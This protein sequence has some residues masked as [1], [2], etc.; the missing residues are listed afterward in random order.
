MDQLPEDRNC[1]KLYFVLDRKTRQWFKC[2]KQGLITGPLKCLEVN[3]TGYYMAR[4]A[5]GNELPF[6]KNEV[7]M[8]FRT[9]PSD[10][11]SGGAFTHEG[12]EQCVVLGE[13][14]MNSYWPKMIN[15]SLRPPAYVYMLGS[16]SPLF[17]AM[18][19]SFP[20][21]GRKSLQASTGQA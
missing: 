12:Q 4:D 6:N 2:C 19:P 14:C 9:R 17:S 20:V 16:P 5:E 13:P 3:P 10:S 1:S 15:S 21:S 8:C 7:Q 18:V 11:W